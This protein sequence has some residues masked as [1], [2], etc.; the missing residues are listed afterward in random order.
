MPVCAT[1][2]TQYGATIRICVRDGTPLVAG[3]VDDPYLGKLL[4]DKYLIESFISSGGLGSVYRAQHVM[5]GK[6]VAVKVIRSELVTSHEVV[7]RF[8]REAR[9]ASNLDHPNIVSV[10][11]L[12][13]AADGTL[14]IAM[15]FIDGPSL[16]DALRRD[17]PMA[18]GRATAILRQ[19]ASALSAAHRRQIVHRD[20]KSHN[21]ML[22]SDDTGGEVVKLVDFGIAKTFD[23]AAT[24][25]T[26]AGYMLG[27]PHY[28]SP[29]QAAGKPVDHR[30]DLY[31][32]G[33][34]LYE[35]LTGA[36][37]FGDESL[38]SVLV[39]LATEIPEKPSARRPDIAVPP[40][41]EAVAM[42][43][44][45]KDPGARFQ[46][47]DEF[48]SA[49]ERAAVDTGTHP[50]G[51]P[52]IPAATLLRPIAPAPRSAPAVPAAAAAPPA[53]RPAAAP[54]DV[55]AAR[56]RSGFSM[57]GQIDRRAAVVLVVIA[58]VGAALASGVALTDD[59]SRPESGVVRPVPDAAVAPPPVF[60]PPA[61]IAASPTPT[62]PEPVPN[63]SLPTDAGG[64]SDPPS[65]GALNPGTSRPAAAA[66]AAGAAVRDTTPSSSRSSG[67]RAP[68]TT[69]G[70]GVAAGPP[71][72]REPETGPAPASTA[73]Q[74]VPRAPAI[75]L[76]C[77][78]FPD[79]CS[80][81]RAEMTRAFQ[82][83]GL[84][85]TRDAAA[86]DIQVAALVVLVSETTSAPFGT[87]MVTRTYSVE[88]DGDARGTPLAVPD[89]RRFSFDPRVG[90]ERL[91][92]NARLIAADAAQAVRAFRARTP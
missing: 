64:R 42:R 13:Q 79:V 17:G 85:V 65:S 7:A 28:M 14:Y 56:V 31:S 87:P 86:A 83:D 30:A 6:T 71:A 34:I 19:V 59:D 43:C 47:A 69:A 18:P 38:T 84:T 67:E 70:T 8:Q 92:E 4:D 16:R 52:P 80:A 82:R 24:Q 75:A 10:Y 11:D 45:E 68:A 74:A 54:D 57:P 72:A 33:V 27:T 9:A 20:L 41:L 89:P 61:P 63:A 50:A 26:Q 73:A 21:L 32:L 39:K 29:E 25:W 81:L 76:A 51:P 37:P 60:P 53:A 66:P 78:G 62:V 3:R 46:S 15:E 36:V 12:G 90:S 5:L 49:L 2:G 35:M 77:E 44:L 1:C 23:E 91:A 88:L 58:A 48:A 55:P 40:A 22:A